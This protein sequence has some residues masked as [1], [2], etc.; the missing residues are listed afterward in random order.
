MNDIESDPDLDFEHLDAGDATCPEG[1]YKVRPKN[2]QVK[3]WRYFCNEC[4]QLPA[5]NAP[6]QKNSAVDNIPGGYIRTQLIDC[7]DDPNFPN[8][9]FIIDGQIQTKPFHKFYA[10]PFA[11]NPVTAPV[12]W[13]TLADL[14]GGYIRSRLFQPGEFPNTFTGG[15]IVEGKFGM[16][17]NRTEMFSRTLTCPSCLQVESK[18]VASKTMYGP[19]FKGL[20]TTKA[21]SGPVFKGLK[22]IGAPITVNGKTYMKY[23]NCK[24]VMMRP[25]EECEN[26]PSQPRL[27]TSGILS[28]APQMKGETRDYLANGWTLQTGD[29][30]QSPN[31]QYVVTQRDNGNLCLAKNG[32]DIW[33]SLQTVPPQ[34]V[35]YKDFYTIIWYNVI[36]TFRGKPTNAILQGVPIWGSL[37]IGTN[38]ANLDRVKEFL[39]ILYSREGGFSQG[40]DRTWLR[41]DDNGNFC[42]VIGPNHQN[43]V[44]ISC[45]PFPRPPI[46]R[47]SISI[48][49]GVDIPL[50]F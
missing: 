18:Q 26:C 15:L 34:A 35:G 8:G 17:T 24:G 30:I 48:L 13:D 6:L 21:A 12:K 7:E 43:A 50:P 22:T 10:C 36:M 1:G 38:E 46:A 27:K 16:N 19:M 29:S 2:G 41:V 14:P 11:T 47:S 42:V 33:C 25:Y 40:N 45:R 28:N 4:Q 31:G 23:Q 49:P 5:D 44:P 20:Q 37:G 9:G 3:K 39:S 32:K